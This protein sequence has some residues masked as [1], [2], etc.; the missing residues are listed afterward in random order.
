MNERPMMKHGVSWKQVVSPENVIHTGSCCCFDPREG[1]LQLS[2]SAKVPQTSH[3][4][5]I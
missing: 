1:H 3:I 4:D 2:V 5:S